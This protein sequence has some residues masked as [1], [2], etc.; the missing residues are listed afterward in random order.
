MV[1]ADGSL[2]YLGRPGLIVFDETHAQPFGLLVQLFIFSPVGLN[3]AIQDLNICFR[4]ALFDGNSVL[5]G[6]HA[7]DARAVFAI[8][9]ASAH[10]L[11]HHHIVGLERPALQQRLQFKLGDHFFAVIV[12]QPGR[13]EHTSA[14][15]DD[16][17]ANTEL[18]LHSSARCRHL[19]VTDISL[20]FV[21][22]CRF[23]DFDVGVLQHLLRMLFREGGSINIGRAEAIQLQ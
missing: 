16:D 12:E 6:G 9:V 7:A 10:A 8:F 1:N 22:N 19:E 14:G 18:F 11:D 2:G 21:D 15:G 3:V 23:E 20:D 17:H 5:D 4:I 13:F